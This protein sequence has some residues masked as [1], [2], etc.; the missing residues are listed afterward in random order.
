LKILR[1]IEPTEPDT[2]DDNRQ[3]FYTASLGFS[4]VPA[5]NI[6]IRPSI[7]YKGTRQEN[8]EHVKENTYIGVGELVFTLYKDNEF[9]LRYQYIDSNDEIDPSLDYTAETVFALFSLKF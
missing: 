7:I 9:I 2:S 4:I 5:H 1:E 3:T 8:V 6:L